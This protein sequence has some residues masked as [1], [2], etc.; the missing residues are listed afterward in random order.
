ELYRRMFDYCSSI[1]V[2]SKHMQR[3]LLELGAPQEKVVYNCYGP[4]NPKKDRSM[5]QMLRF[6][7][8]GRFVDKKAPYLT[9]LAFLEVLRSFPRAILSLVGD[10]PLE[11]AC[12]NLVRALGIGDN[13]EFLGVLSHS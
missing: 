8:V 1:I 6:I 10:G 12:K 4:T 13:V 7:S 2:V 11:F 3:R 5:P 9:I